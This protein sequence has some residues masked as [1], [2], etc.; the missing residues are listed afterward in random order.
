M[1]RAP[2]CCH[3]TCFVFL[4]ETCVQDNWYCEMFYHRFHWIWGSGDHKRPHWGWVD[5]R[6]GLD[7]DRVCL[8]SGWGWVGLRIG[9][10]W[11]RVGLRIG[12]G[13][14]G[15]RIGL[16]WDRVGLRSGWGWVGLR[17]GLDWGRVCLRS[18]WGWVG[19]RSGLEFR[20]KETLFRLP[21]I[22]T[23][24]VQPVEQP[25]AA[26]VLSNRNCEL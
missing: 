26:P 23:C 6:N 2:M 19:L 22:P 18:G 13:W 5:P 21:E 4:F 20:R 14:V 10:D 7:W 17:I 16:D 1:L 15:L 25:R 9:L 24:N 3:A 8:R 12:W 11:G